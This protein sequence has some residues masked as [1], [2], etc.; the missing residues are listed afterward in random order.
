LE[1][2]GKG[3]YCAAGDFH[4]DPWSPV[5]RAVIT[6][7]HSDHARAGS[8]SYLCARAGE[9]VLR[10]RLGGVS[11]QALE[12]GEAVTIG[13]ARV[14]LHPAGHILGSAQVRV[15]AAGRVACV[16]GDY[17]TTPDATAAAF[18][19]VPCH[20]FVT[21]ATFALPVYRWRP[22]GEVFEA[23]NAWWAR[24]AAGGRTSVLYGYALGKAQRLLSGLDP[25]TGPIL[26]HGAVEKLAAC[27]REAGV[28]LPEAKHAGAA[29]KDE[30]KR[31][32]VL[33]PPSANGTPWVRRFGDFAAA[34]ASGW[35]AIRGARRR[36]AVDR[37]FVLSDHADW[38]GLLAAIGATGAEEVWVTHGYT[39][40]LARWLSERGVKA[41]ALA[42]RF[43][44]ELI[45]R[46]EDPAS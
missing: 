10:A 9:G 41:K 42:T 37:G 30:L 32:L 44:G 38:P 31:A 45:D 5:E 12:Y 1:L 24:N 29:S 18:E 35:M 43:E 25:A 33:A 15:E 8:S 28:A 26:L 36:R 7:A 6:H 21:E 11:I 14:S 17:K 39:G 3:F 27:Y 22:D 16:S 13:D 19:P 2:T 23:V 34:L 4:I 20:L 40:P 46:E